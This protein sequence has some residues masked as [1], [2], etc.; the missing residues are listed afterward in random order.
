MHLFVYRIC[1]FLGKYTG[2]IIINF[3]LL[4]PSIEVNY[5]FLFGYNIL[6]CYIQ[7]HDLMNCVIKRVLCV[8]IFV[9]TLVDPKVA[10]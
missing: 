6:F 7:N 4:I 8:G 10:Q 3:Y 2:C 1:K 5:T 9:V